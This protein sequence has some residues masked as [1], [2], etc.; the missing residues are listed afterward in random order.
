MSKQNKKPVTI[1][2]HSMYDYEDPKVLRNSV[3]YTRFRNAV[4]EKDQCRCIVCGSTQDIEV[5]H[6]Y[7]F[8]NY[9]ADRFDENNGVCVCAEHHSIKCP[10]SFHSI[11]GT[12]N[13][14]PEQFESY[15]NYMRNQLGIKE[16]FDVYEYMNPYDADNMEID[17]SMLDLYE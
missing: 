5:H 1:S 14:T 3:E 8:S 10:N 13:N 12:R 17:D 16:H 9:N 4:K 2:F 7:P 6:L 15:V 11:F